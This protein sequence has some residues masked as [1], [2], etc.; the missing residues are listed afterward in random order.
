MSKEE[1]AKIDDLAMSAWDHHSVEEFAG[2]LADDFTWID[3]TVPDPMRSTEEISRYMQ[4]WFTA[5]PDMRVRTTN[6]V[7]AEDQVAAEIEFSGTNS[8]TLSLGG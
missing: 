7:I 2:L 6:R 4:A 1:V 3:D 5:F 8:G